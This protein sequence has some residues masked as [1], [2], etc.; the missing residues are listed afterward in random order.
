MNRGPLEDTLQAAV[1]TAQQRAI[2]PSSQN[3]CTQ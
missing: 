2:F 3:G 1:R